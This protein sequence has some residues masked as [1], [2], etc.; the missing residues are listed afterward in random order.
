M[1]RESGV[2]DVTHRPLVPW[3]MAS[4]IGQGTELV[5]R[6]CLYRLECMNSVGYGWVLWDTVRFGWVRLGTVGI[7][8]R[9]VYGSSVVCFFPG[10]PEQ[11]SVRGT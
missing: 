11:H 5:R 7:W 8:L 9:S 10:Q 2:H 6:F 3:P 4:A 1:R